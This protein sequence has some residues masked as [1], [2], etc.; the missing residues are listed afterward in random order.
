VTVNRVY[1]GGFF[2]KIRLF[3][4]RLKEL[5][6]FEPRRSG[7]SW[8]PCCVFVNSLSDFWHEK[9]PDK[10]IHDALDEFERHPNKI[11]QILTK[12]PGRMRRFIEDRYKKTRVPEHF[13]LG[14]TAED[15]RVKRTLD[16]MRA[17]KAY[18]G[19]FTAFASVE[20]ITAPTDELD[21]SDI[22][23]V[24]TGGESGPKARAMKFKWLE[25][26]HDV[27]LGAG[28]PLHFKQYGTAQNNPLARAIYSRDHWKRHAPT[29]SG[30]LQEAITAG[31]ELAPDEKGGATYKGKVYH[32]KPPHYHK[33]KA[34]L[35][36]RKI[37]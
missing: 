7:T 11:F 19:N 32:E 36:K 26:V 18:V 34:E 22:D 35:N 14:V 6:K 30:A 16:I 21:F 20:P 13:W 4:Q 17:T 12:R 25:T 2:D 27:V 1:G 3:P 5:R 23:W 8:I 24:L 29:F 15:N 28:I 31:Q 33:L 10:F 9:I 37:V